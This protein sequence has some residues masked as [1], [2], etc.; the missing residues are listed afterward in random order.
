MSVTLPAEEDFI[1]QCQLKYESET[2]PEGMQWEKA[3]LGETESIMLWSCDR[4]LH[5]LIRCEAEGTNRAI[6][7]ALF[8]QD[9]NNLVVYYPDFVELYTR[10]F[11]GE[12]KQKVRWW[13]NANGETV[14]SPTKPNGNWKQG[15]KWTFNN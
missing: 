5:T 3:P 8:I 4:T 12:G 11:R 2:I 9:M 15:R 7:R 13:V 1:L 6:N 14:R 10:W